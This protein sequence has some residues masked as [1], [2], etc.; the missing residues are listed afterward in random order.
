MRDSK[1]RVPLTSAQRFIW[2]HQLINPSCPAY[3]VAQFIRIKGPVD[4]SAMNSAHDCIVRGT[5]IFRLRFGSEQGEPYQYVVPAR[6]TDSSDGICAHRT[7]L[8]RMPESY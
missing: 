3:N 2:Y 5:E 6:G 1:M 8:K 4:L 7:N